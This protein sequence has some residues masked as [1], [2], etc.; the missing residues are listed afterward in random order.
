MNTKPE[1]GGRGCLGQVGRFPGIAVIADGTANSETV[2]NANLPVVRT[3]LM[4][5]TV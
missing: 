1:T 2:A 3:E 4:R 5:M